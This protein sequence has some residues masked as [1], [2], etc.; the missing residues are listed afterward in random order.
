IIQ[1]SHLLKSAMLGLVIREQGKKDQKLRMSAV[2]WD[3]FTG[4]ATYRN[5]FLRFLNPML[6]IPLIWSIMKTLVLNGKKV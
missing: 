4:S 1:K 5:I 2:L 6:L 3:T